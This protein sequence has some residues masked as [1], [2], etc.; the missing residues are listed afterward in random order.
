MAPAFVIEIR[1]GHESAPIHE[2]PLD[3]FA[4]TLGLDFRIREPL[5]AGRRSRTAP[6][7][8][9]APAF[10]HAPVRDPR[11]APSCA[12]MAGRE[13]EGLIPVVADVESFALPRADAGAPATAAAAV[14]SVAALCGTDSRLHAS[15]AT[16]Q[17]AMNT[18]Q[19]NGDTQFCLV[20]PASVGQRQSHPLPRSPRVKRHHH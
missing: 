2:L 4:W 11:I 18:F 7:V 6:A 14:P 19:L 12:V 17:S 20:Y 10:A 1:A 5:L 3:R 13:S 15:M 8:W 16:R 9:C